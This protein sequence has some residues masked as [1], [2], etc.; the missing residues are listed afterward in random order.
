VSNSLYQRP[1]IGRRVR[2]AMNYQ[3]FQKKIHISKDHL[4]QAIYQA[5]RDRIRVKKKETVLRNLARI[6]DAALKISNQKGF[7]AMSMRDFSKETGLS[8]GALYS[9]FASKDELLD[10]ILRQG[11]ELVLRILRQN[12]QSIGDPIAKL[13]KAIRVHIYLSEALQPWFHFSFMEA[14]NMS[15]PEKE[16]TVASEL[17]TDQMFA[18]ILVEGQTAGL[19]APRD[20]QPS[21]GG[22]KAL[23]QDWYVKR[24]KYARRKTTVDQYADF[25]VEFVMA[26]HLRVPP[27][28]PQ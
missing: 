25:I 22:I 24:W 9:Y 28:Q 18:D 20:P 12:I 7:Q 15:A 3:Q 5:N 16:K 27:K 10:M 4:Y 23:L 11:R 6:F 19:F 8:I 17:H 21:A 1:A 26:Y 2:I 14:K 13:E